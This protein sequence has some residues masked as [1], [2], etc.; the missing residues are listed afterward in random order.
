M[1]HN[2]PQLTQPIVVRLSITDD[3]ADPTGKLFYQVNDGA[4]TMVL[5]TNESETEFVAE[6]PGVTEASVVNYYIEATD[7]GNNT[8]REPSVGEYAIHIGISDPVLMI[9]EFMSSN[10]NTIVDNYGATEDWI[11]IKNISN[12]AVSLDGKYLTDD[13][14][15][16][17]RFK[18]PDVTLEPDQYYIIW[19]DDDREQGPNHANFKLSA[20]GESIGL[21]DSYETDYTP[22]FTL[23]YLSQESNIS[24]GYNTSGDLIPQSFI[25]PRGENTS[26]DVA[27]I[28]FRFNMNRQI[29]NGNF[30]PAMD[31]IDVAGSFNNWEG[32][33]KVYDGN[34]DGI[35]QYTTLGFT[36]NQT[37]EYK[38]RINADWNTAEFPEHGGAGNRVYTLVSGHNIIEH[39]YNEA[40]TGIDDA[41]SDVMLTV[42]PNP[43]T[44][45]NFAVKSTFKMEAI[46]IYSLTG[47][48]VYQK[49]NYNVNELHVDVELDKGIYIVKV[50]GSDQE[51]IT[52]LIV[53]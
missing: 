5:L 38:A 22:I 26:N 51:Y 52:K 35:Y 49:E 33:D 45:G 10:T 28:T 1:H 8:T 44:S 25:T 42:F 21:F 16:F 36:T 7:A 9:T 46:L 14:T 20:S 11:E 4:F 6:I 32:D 34:E 41:I 2:F 30:N 47:N 23:D 15:K 48:V 18:L 17:N 29:E 43:T 53:Y 12:N 39:W 24:S 3:Q 40:G 19:A 27:F 50:F 31:F 13:L 37:I